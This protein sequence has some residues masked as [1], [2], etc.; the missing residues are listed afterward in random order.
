M[1]LMPGCRFG[2]VADGGGRATGYWM[3][4]RKMARNVRRMEVVGILVLVVVVGSA[5][6]L[7]THREVSNAPTARATGSLAT[8][9]GVGGLSLLPLGSVNT[10][11]ATVPVG[12]W[13]ETPA[14]DSG[15]GDLYVPNGD[16]H[17]VSVISG[18]TNA[19]VATVQVG[20]TPSVAAYDSSTGDVYV[21]NMFTNNV[22]VIWGAANR[23]V[24][25][26]PVGSNPYGAAYDSGNGDVYVPNYGSSNVSVISG[27]TNT[28]VAT[29]SVGS[30]PQGSAYD[31]ANGELYVA[32][33]FSADVSVISGVTDKVVATVPV[34]SAP[35]TPAYDSG[36]GEVYVA[37]SESHNV[38]AISGA[39]NAVVATVPVGYFPTTPT[40]DTEN[41]E[42][43]V[44]TSDD[45][46]VSAI[47]G[48]TNTVVATI[49]V[50]GSPMTPTYDSGNG[51]LYVP[52]YYSGEVTVV[53][54]GTNVVF[55]ETG[56]ASGTSWSAVLD[57]ALATSTSTTV[58]FTVLPGDHSYQLA[59]VAN[60]TV[61]PSSGT[62]FVGVAS[63]LVLVTFSS[64]AIPKY[65]V[66]IEETGLSSGTNWSAIFGGTKESTNGSVL[67]FAVSEGTYAYEVLPVAGWVVSPSSG[68]ATVE[69]NYLITVAFSSPTP[70]TQVSVVGYSEGFTVAIAV[71]AVAL[72]FAVATLILT[73]RPRPPSERSP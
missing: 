63:Y 47:S 29:V 19:V 15:N 7:G 20:G 41:G 26:V 50:G 55:A 67:T 21:V 48:A 44:A 51:E 54:G 30:G 42:L 6:V 49:M 27:A 34:G 16:S 35:V 70:T 71:A 61:S 58:I 66:T 1:L 52:S 3:Q 14:Y 31:S 36:N 8:E 13:P 22:S 43:Y 64:T 28:V 10:V 23:V 45:D 40:F 37:N 17:N 65:T 73:R 2:P 38:S 4:A 72:G 57:G 56:L 33:S 46:N 11:V 69:G 18:A 9:V 32:N 39:T 5:S 24:A 62:A 60:Y 12:T 68:T 53:E 59:P 25:T